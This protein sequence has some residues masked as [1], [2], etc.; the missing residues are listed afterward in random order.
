MFTRKTPWIPVL[1]WMGIIF[2]LSSQPASQSNELSSGITKM[3][4]DFVSGVVPGSAPELI[5]LNHIIRKNAHFIAYFILGVFTVN[6]LYLNRLKE[7]RAFFMS[8]TISVAYAALDEFHQ[9]FVP[10]RSGELRDVL[11]DSMG[12]LVGIALYL[13]VM[14]FAL[15]DRKRGQRNNQGGIL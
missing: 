5:N 4:I 15:N 6:A 12:A 13:L 10:G 2:Y 1:V 14:R 11:I 9:T 7:T 3:I 8:L